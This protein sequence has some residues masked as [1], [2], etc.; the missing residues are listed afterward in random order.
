MVLQSADSNHVKPCLYTAHVSVPQSD[1]VFLVHST[2]SK[3]KAASFAIMSANWGMEEDRKRQQ[4]CEI[5]SA[6]PSANR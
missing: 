5:L 2:V 4:I 1:T 3:R 6:I